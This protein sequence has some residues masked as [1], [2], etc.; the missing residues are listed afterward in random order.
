MLAHELVRANV[1]QQ[2]GGGGGGGGGDGGG[3]DA[4]A[5][6]SAT[7]GGGGG[8]R[9]R[10][11][12][13]GSLADAPAPEGRVAKRGRP[14]SDGRASG[15]SDG[16]GSGEHPAG[17]N[18]SGGGAGGGVGGAGGGGG[19]SGGSGGH[20]N[21]GAP[22]L[23]APSWDLAAL[24]KLPA[25]L[26]RQLVDDWEF[27][28]KDHKRVPLP[29]EPNVCS[30]LTGWLSE[31]AGG[32]AGAGG[33]GLWGGGGAGS[34]SGSGGGGVGA[35]GGG[36]GAGQ[37]GGG[38]GGGSGSGG[39]VSCGPAGAAD[40][41]SR[42]VAEGLREYFDAALPTIL[43]YRV[44]RP[45]YN[46]VM[47]AGGRGGSRLRPS[48]VYGAEHLLRLLVKLPDLLAAEEVEPTV[49]R[50]IAERVNDIARFMQKN[51]RLLFC[52][53]YEAVEGG[54]GGGAADG[55]VAG[56]PSPMAPP[57]APPAPAPALSGGA[58]GGGGDRL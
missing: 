18:G 14:A 7:G 11:P 28:T 34:G 40:R 51:A 41:T 1:Q 42:D 52:L 55:G 39:G 8:G 58:E 24:F 35:G 48:K 44:E 57:P 43:L 49:L 19:R 22:L 16:G 27:V 2:P 47:A 4:T 23:S 36:G 12:M 30:V 31:S 6:T 9:K 3:R 21:G 46:A 20:A 17:A 38:G 5:T 25:P 15:D 50:A 10:G 13:G 29:R 26:K 33:G 37:A 32:G 53:D 56:R 45:Q 54:G